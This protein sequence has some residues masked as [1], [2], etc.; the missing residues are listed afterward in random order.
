MK[1]Q[2]LRNI[3]LLYEREAL[4]IEILADRPKIMAF[5]KNSYQLWLSA[6]WSKETAHDVFYGAGWMY[7]VLGRQ[8]ARKSCMSH[9]R[10]AKETGETLP[11]IEPVATVLGYTRDIA[12]EMQE[13]LQTKTP[14]DA[15]VG[16]QTPGFVNSVTSQDLNDLHDFVRDRQTD[17]PM[18]DHPPVPIE[19]QDRIIEKMLHLAD[20]NRDKVEILYETAH[21]ACMGYGG[22]EQGVKLGITHDPHMTPFK[23]LLTNWHEIGHAV[24]RQSIPFGQFVAGRAMDEAIA[25]LFEYWVGYSD[26]FLQMLLDEGLTQCGYDMAMLKSHA[27]EIVRNT[28]RIETNPIRHIIDI[29]LCDQFER[30]LVNEDIE[31]EECELFWARLIEPYADILPADYLYYYDVHM[32]SGIY[33]DRACY[34][35][36]LLAAIQ[37]GEGKGVTI[38]NFKDVVKEIADSGHTHFDKAV[39]DITGANLST[40]AFKNWIKLNF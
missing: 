8:L 39:M 9:W 40:S 3:S 20:I 34:T 12:M 19:T 1:G 18:S 23:S 13:F 17:A 4:K 10:K 11:L 27:A 28:K 21:P 22:V 30:A 36:G 15:L 16:F 14:Y 33:G 24:Y 25:F 32:M 2:D 37:I 6:Q 26:D 35:P 5:I 29:R 31:A 7:E 38:N